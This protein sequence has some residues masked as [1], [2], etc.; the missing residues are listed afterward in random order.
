MDKE[1][2]KVSVDNL[3]RMQLDFLK[4]HSIKILNDIII[5]I[6]NENFEAIE[7]YCSNSPAG[8]LGEDNQY[9]DFGYDKES[10]DISQITNQM[11]CLRTQIIRGKEKK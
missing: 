8:D 9:I 5:C 3:A 4:E 6:Q 1:I 2:M 11:W 7:D 10:K